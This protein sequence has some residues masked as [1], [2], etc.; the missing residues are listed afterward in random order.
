MLLLKIDKLDRHKM[1]LLLL[2]M[3]NYMVQLLYTFW[4]VLA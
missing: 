4:H 1:S 2:Y 3:T